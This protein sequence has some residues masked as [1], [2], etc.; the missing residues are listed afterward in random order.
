[1]QEL[2]METLERLL[3]DCGSLPEYQGAIIVEHRRDVEALVY[4]LAKVN[5]ENPIPR[6]IDIR[7][8]P[9]GAVVRFANDSY[10]D[11]SL[12]ECVRGERYNTLL[13]HGEFT[14][15]VLDRFMMAE[16]PYWE[17]RTF[18]IYDRE[19]REMITKNFWK[20]ATFD[21]VDPMDNVTDTEELDNFLNSFSIKP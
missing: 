1:M 2:N 11:I 20:P 8:T 9:Q 10:I 3:L 16:R 17:S 5:R 21:D 4:E 15:R 12:F 6:L 7:H 19:F 13:Y 14:P 18:D